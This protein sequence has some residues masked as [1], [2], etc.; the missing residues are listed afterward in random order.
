MFASELCFISLFTRTIKFPS[1]GER[2]VHFF[3]LF[4]V[5][6][7][8]RIG[9]FNLF[10]LSIR[11]TCSFYCC[12]YHEKWFFAVFCQYSFLFVLRNCDSVSCV[13][14]IGIPLSSLV[15]NMMMYIEIYWR[16]LFCL[17]QV[18]NKE[19]INIIYNATH[20]QSSDHSVISFNE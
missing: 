1:F 12:R 2:F 18:E 15:L 9:D 19:I 11:I 3:G 20:K 6:F 17:S 7:K 10:K 14:S 13:G 16:P 8:N 4:L 5:H